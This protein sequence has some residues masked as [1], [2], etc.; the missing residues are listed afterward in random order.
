MRTQA[1]IFRQYLPESLSGCELC[2]SATPPRASQ[3][4]RCGC[5]LSRRETAAQSECSC[6]VVVEY[7]AFIAYL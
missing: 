7:Q 6:R 2:C 5:S 3:S 1:N 4:D